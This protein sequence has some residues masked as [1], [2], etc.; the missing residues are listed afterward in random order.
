MGGWQVAYFVQEYTNMHISSLS[1]QPKYESLWPGKPNFLV[2]IWKGLNEMNMFSLD[3]SSIIRLMLMPFWLLEIILIGE[4]FLKSVLN[5]L[6][7]SF[8]WY[9]LICKESDFHLAIW[10]AKLQCQ[11]LRQAFQNSFNLPLTNISPLGFGGSGGRSSLSSF[12]KASFT[13]TFSTKTS[14]TLASLL[15]A[16]FVIW[17]PV[18]SILAVLICLS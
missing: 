13:F 2:V 1:S 18:S 11:A 3:R 17:L 7:P 10:L 5:L 8:L 6:W 4:F 14:T 15:V 12:E 16:L 9:I